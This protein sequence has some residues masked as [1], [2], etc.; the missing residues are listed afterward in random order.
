MLDRVGDTWQ[1]AAVPFP[2]VF[3]SGIMRGRFSPADGQLYL[4][5]LR[6]WGTSAA[7]DSTFCRVRYTG[8][9]FDMPV[10]WKVTEDGVAL[11]FDRPLDAD[12]ATDDQ[13]WIVETSNVPFGTNVET[14]RQ[15]EVFLDD[16]ELSADGKTIS[17][18]FE[19]HEP[20]TNLRIEY[21]IESADGTKLSSVIYGTINKI[22]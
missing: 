19:E 11:T 1:G 8:G 9:P 16:A 7:R 12:S 17:L 21:R 6:G 2:L 15:D 20:V 3:T 14:K 13:N 10:D 22:P 5:G 18:V 4:C